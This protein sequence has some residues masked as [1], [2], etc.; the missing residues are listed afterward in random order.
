MPEPEMKPLA[1]LAHRAPYKKYI[2]YHADK[3]QLK[4]CPFKIDIATR[5]IDTAPSKAICRA[6]KNY[7]WSKF[8]E[9]HLEA[10]LLKIDSTEPL[11]NKRTRDRAGLDDHL[12]REHR[13]DPYDYSKDSKTKRKGFK[14]IIKQEED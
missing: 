13:L 6:P 12:K 8:E 5:Y 1:T 9:G 4:N 2:Q 11:C 14:A 3:I 7:K 10:N